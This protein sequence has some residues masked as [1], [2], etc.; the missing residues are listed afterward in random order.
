MSGCDKGFEEYVMERLDDIVLQLK[1][2]ASALEAIAQS[3][4]TEEIRVE[5]KKNSRESARK[6]KVE[7][8]WKSYRELNKAIKEEA[9]TLLENIKDVKR[10]K[11]GDFLIKIDYVS[12][13]DFKRIADE[14][15][16]LGGEY[17]KKYRGFIFKGEA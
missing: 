17:S 4:N 2:L 15:R 13:E 14:A 1:R 11:S 10:F 6:E 16:A 3:L 9:P 5:P 8:T 12:N 7:R